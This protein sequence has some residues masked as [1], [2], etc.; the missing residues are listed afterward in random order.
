MYLGT[1]VQ[2]GQLFYNQG[3]GNNNDGFVLK[4]NDAGAS[5]G[6][7]WAQRVAGPVDDEVGALAIDGNN[8]YLGGYFGGSMSMG[9]TTLT[10]AGGSDAFVA[11]LVDNG[12]SRTFAWAKRMGGAGSDEVRALA[13]RGGTLYAAGDFYSTT[14]DFGSTTLTNPVAGS[15]K[16]TLFVAKMLDASNGAFAWVKGV[17]GTGYTIPINL[18][19][20]GVHVNV[21]GRGEATSTFD[22]LSFASTTGND[23]AFWAS[24]S[25]PTL[26]ATTP[27]LRPE[28]II[29]FPNPAHTATTVQLP[30][31]PGAT[32]VALTVLDALGR[33]LRTQTAATNARTD[34]NLTGLPAGLYA[35]R[36]QAGASTATR[37]LVVE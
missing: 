13:V 10:T 1:P 36:V 30:A 25:D 18:T 33:T 37:R 26:T 17:G 28:S 34:I 21:T 24:F 29:L 12:T 31:I 8:L 14:A 7:V 11:K 6:L 9:T 15:Q 35:L 4:L 5:F 32:T 20:E 23:L 2:G 22:N 3:G 19:L 16:A 27:A